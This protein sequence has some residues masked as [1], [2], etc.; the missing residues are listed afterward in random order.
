VKSAKAVQVVEVSE[1]KCML[2]LSALL[3][4]SGFFSL[5]WE[6]ESFPF[7]YGLGF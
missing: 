7:E 4:C 2:P 5:L 1:A 6:N 3:H